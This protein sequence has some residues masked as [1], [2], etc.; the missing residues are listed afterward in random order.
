VAEE[1]LSLDFGKH[2]DVVFRRAPLVRVLCQIKFPPI[3]SLLTPVGVTGFQTALRSYYPTMLP[4]EQGASIAVE[5]ETI[6]IKSNAPVW[7]MVNEAQDWTVGLASDFVSLE[8]PS[9]TSIVEFLQRFDFVLS[10]L[11]RTVRPADSVRIGFRK[12][13]LISSTEYSDNPDNLCQLI[14][15]ELLGP[16]AA[17]S[18]PAKITSSF[19]IQQFADDDNI[20]AVRYGFAEVNSQPGFILDTDYFT[21]RPYGIEANS[22]TE[23]L[24]YFSDG[25]TSFFH[26][27]LTDDFK[28]RLEPIP[29]SAE[30]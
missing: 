1:P 13:N 14:R 27:A 24:R 20:L 10:V 15:G 18:L 6:G 25:M 11:R 17:D 12:V 7:R 3:L 21:T 4:P 30:R 19:S 8:T 28:T 26:W 23:L 9:Y 16:L 29:R 22:I 2:S 5:N